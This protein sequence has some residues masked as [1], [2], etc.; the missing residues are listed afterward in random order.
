MCRESNRGTTA[1]PLIRMGSRSL[2]ASDPARTWNPETL[3]PWNPLDQT[4]KLTQN[5]GGGSPYLMAEQV[6]V[7]VLHRDALADAGAAANVRCV[8]ER[9]KRH[10]QDFL[11][12]TGGRNETRTRVRNTHDGVQRKAADEDMDRSELSEHTN[13][14]RID[15]DLLLR[16]AQGGLGEGLAWV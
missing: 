9:G 3:E 12:L 5:H 16:F 11:Y 4:D 1:P 2:V 14:R 15:V 7:R 10:R 6:E 8:T 13:R